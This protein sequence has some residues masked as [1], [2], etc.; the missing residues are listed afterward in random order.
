M[1]ERVNF[2]ATAPDTFAALAGTEHLTRL[3]TD[4]M[5]DEAY[6]ALAET[7][8]PGEIANLT[9]LIGTINLWNRLA[10]GLNRP[11]PRHS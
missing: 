1:R 2:D 7:V 5:P 11:L 8:T 9:A 4:G 6:S 3:A 10:V